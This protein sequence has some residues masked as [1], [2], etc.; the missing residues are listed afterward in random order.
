MSAFYV[1]AG[2]SDGTCEPVV[3]V[4]DR[5]GKPHVEHRLTPE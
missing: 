1:R 5:R 2:F 3:C 4:T